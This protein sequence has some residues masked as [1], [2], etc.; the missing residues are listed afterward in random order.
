MAFDAGVLVVIQAGSAHL[1][2]LHGKAQ[3][4]NQMQAAA[5]VGGQTDD[6]AGVGW[7]FGLNQNDVKHA[8]F[9]C[10]SLHCGLA[11]KQVCVPAPPHPPASPPPPAKSACVQAS[12][13]VPVVVTS[14][15]STTLASRKCLQ[16][17]CGLTMKAS[18]KVVQPALDETSLI[19]R[20]VSPQAN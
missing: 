5:R 17:R 2:V 7:N 3:R 14:S 18:V 20:R 19:G 1:F 4:L 8:V 12:K 10:L 9:R 11:L 16:M 6:V 13:V 15:T